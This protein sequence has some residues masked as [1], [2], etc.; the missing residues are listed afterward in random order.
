VPFDGEFLIN[1][2]PAPDD[3][4]NEHTWALEAGYDGQLAPGLNVQLDLYHQRFEDLIG[5]DTVPDPEGL[6]RAFFVAANGEGADAR[7]VELQVEVT[8]P[9]WSLTAWYAYNDFDA[10][11]PVQSLRAFLPARHKAGL[12]GRL[13]FGEGWVANLGYK[14]QSTTPGEPGTDNKAPSFHRLDLTLARGLGRVEVLAGVSDLFNRDH[15]SV[16]G[17]SQLTGH[18]TPGRSLFGRLQVRF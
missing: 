18:E 7:G 1:L 10:D 16:F 11:R 15:G 14:F 4:D 8:R 9:D 5:F 2:L 12:T 17:I 13:R 3:P 6:G